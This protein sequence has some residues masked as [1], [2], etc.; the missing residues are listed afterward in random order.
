MTECQSMLFRTLLPINFRVENWHT[1]LCVK[2]NL[3]SLNPS[4]TEDD[5]V[6][7]RTLCLLLW[8]ALTVNVNF[9]Q[10]GTPWVNMNLLFDISKW[11]GEQEGWNCLFYGLTPRRQK[12]RFVCNCSRI[13]AANKMALLAKKYVVVSRLN[14]YA[15]NAKPKCYI[16]IYPQIR[17]VESLEV[18]WKNT[19]SSQSTLLI[20]SKKLY[21]LHTGQSNTK[22]EYNGK[23]CI[24]VWPTVK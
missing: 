22:R 11:F 14:L 21:Q 15:Q 6:C 18:D 7:F 2:R 3:W 17:Q 5:K 8:T 13:H 1:R 4:K 9:A 23:K 24:V 10:G 20:N 16:W 12:Q 19:I